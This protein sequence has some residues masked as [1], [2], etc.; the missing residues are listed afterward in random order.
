MPVVTVLTGPVAL[1]SWQDWLAAWLP[2]VA[3]RT[4]V[5]TSG[6]PFDLEFCIPSSNPRRHDGL[7]VKWLSQAV[8]TVI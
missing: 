7:V 2:V 3:A 1:P 8:T 6:I 5:S 4:Y